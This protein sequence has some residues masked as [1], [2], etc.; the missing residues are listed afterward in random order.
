M[1]SPTLSPTPPPKKLLLS[2][3]WPAPVPTQLLCSFCSFFS[4]SLFP[5]INLSYQLSEGLFFL[6]AH[7]KLESVHAHT[8]LQICALTPPPT[9]TITHLHIYTSTHAS[10]LI[11]MCTH[12]YTCT[13]THRHTSIYHITPASLS[14]AHTSTPGVTNP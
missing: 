1:A 10:T 9:H 8:H 11:Y 13:C 4:G 3:S 5:K 14:S 12:T 2:L 6:T 7:S